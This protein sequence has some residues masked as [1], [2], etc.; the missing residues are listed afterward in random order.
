MAHAGPKHGEAGHECCGLGKVEGDGCESANVREAHPTAASSVGMDRH[1]AEVEPI[2]VAAHSAGRDPKV[3]GKLGESQP[4]SA[5]R[6]KPFD[7][8]L[9]A[10]NAPQGEG[11]VA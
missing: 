4:G 6:V 9:L 8:R 11:T 5:S 10:F 1:S 3:L 2:D 7:K